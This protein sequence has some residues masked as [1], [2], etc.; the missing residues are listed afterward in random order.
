MYHCEHKLNYS[1]RTILVP[2]LAVVP[3]PYADIFLISL[4]EYLNRPRALQWP[5]PP[6]DG[7]YFTLWLR[8]NTLL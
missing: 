4:Q 8:K 7:A 1:L 3:S 5:T 2:A 6:R